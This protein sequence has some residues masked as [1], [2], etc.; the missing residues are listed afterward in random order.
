MILLQPVHK[1]IKEFNNFVPVNICQWLSSTS[2]GFCWFT[3][4]PPRWFGSLHTKSIKLP[5]KSSYS[6]PTSQQHIHK[7]QNTI[8]KKLWKPECRGWGAVKSPFSGSPWDGQISS[9]KRPLVAVW[10]LSP[11]T[12]LPLGLVFL[13]AQ[14][15]LLVIWS[16]VK[17]QFTL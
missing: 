11:G 10:T 8:Q 2:R 1:G 13:L 12:L 7:A 4:L 9:P 3:R 5:T 15:T 16:S 14:I 6:V 17:S